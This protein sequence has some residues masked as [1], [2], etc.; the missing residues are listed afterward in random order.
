[1]SITIKIPI[2][3]VLSIVISGCTNDESGAD[4]DLSNDEQDAPKEEPQSSDD[5]HEVLDELIADLDAPPEDLAEALEQS[6]GPLQQKRI[7]DDEEA[8][9][10]VMAPLMEFDAE[11]WDDS[12][13]THDQ[14]WTLVHS[15]VAA[16][17]PGPNSIVQQI[18]QSQIG[19]PDF[20][21]DG[22]F[23]F[24]DQFNVQL[25]LDA[26]GSMAG[27]IDGTSKMDIAKDSILAFIDTLPEDAQVGLRVYGH[28]G[29]NTSEGQEVSCQSSELIY[30]I[31]E[32]DEGEISDVLNDIEPTGWT[33][34]SYSLQEA[35]RDFMEYPGEENTDIIYL[36]VTELKRVMAIRL[37]QQNS[38]VHRM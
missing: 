33:P 21:E 34:I 17:F 27:E 12:E 24:E 29:D 13:E 31:Q 38:S 14:L 1:M 4:E 10:E 2:F 28:E 30:D 22:T 19:H 23:S 15:W 6:A 35:E 20:E 16:D 8:F 3:I 7:D 25:I 36:S 11:E 5:P 26:S 18:R 9:M 32:Y 37:R